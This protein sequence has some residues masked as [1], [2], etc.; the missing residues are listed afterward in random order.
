MDPIDVVHNSV[1]DAVDTYKQLYDLQ[2]VIATN[3][4]D[5]PLGVMKAWR[6][7]FWGEERQL[8][9]FLCDDR[10]AVAEDEGG[11]NITQTDLDHRTFSANVVLNW[12]DRFFPR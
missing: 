11:D 1:F 7:K 8:G 2:L 6:L 5:T 12:I 4:V 9:F 3:T 10:L